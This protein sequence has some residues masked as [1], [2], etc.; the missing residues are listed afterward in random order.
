MEV[1][2]LADRYLVDHVKVECERRLLNLDAVSALRVLRQADKPVITSKIREDAV[3]VRLTTK[4]RISNS[5]HH[6]TRIC[7]VTRLGDA[8]LH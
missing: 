7:H 4:G 6:E 2:E 5:A 8:D 1:L 3:R